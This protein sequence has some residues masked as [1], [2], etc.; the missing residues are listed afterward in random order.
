MRFRVFVYKVNRHTHS[1]F[2]ISATNALAPAHASKTWRMGKKRI[3]PKPF[4]WL[5]CLETPLPQVVF[6]QDTGTQVLYPVPWATR[7]LLLQCYV[8]ILRSYR[9]SRIHITT[10]AWKTQAL[11]PPWK[12]Q[13]VRHY[14]CP[15]FKTNQPTRHATRRI[16]SSSLTASSIAAFDCGQRKALSR[17]ASP[18]P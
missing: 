1:H 14:T 3:N 10:L 12:Q 2:H 4:H 6:I 18:L 17:R 9:H 7:R 13:N 5:L 16:L 8:H 11:L 15:V